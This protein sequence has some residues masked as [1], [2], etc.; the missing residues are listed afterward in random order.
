MSWPPPLLPAG[1]ARVAI[2][3]LLLGAVIIAFSGI[4]LA[5]LGSAE[6]IADKASLRETTARPEPGRMSPQ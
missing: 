3:A 2:V 5:R 6:E 1:P 4:F